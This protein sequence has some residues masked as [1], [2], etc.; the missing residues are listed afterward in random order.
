VQLASKTLR[1]F[2]AGSILV[3]ALALT[4]PAWA[5]PPTSDGT[6]TPSVSLLE[7]GVVQ[8]RPASQSTNAQTTQPAPLGPLSPEAPASNGPVAVVYVILLV[9][10]PLLTVATVGWMQT[11]RRVPVRV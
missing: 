10:M 5:Q 7:G 8:T 3:F 2:V 4:T 9:T 11:R 6:S 1:A